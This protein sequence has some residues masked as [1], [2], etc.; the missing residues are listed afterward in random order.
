G[1]P[2]AL[3]A[4]LNC[5]P[6]NSR[7]TRIPWT[8]LWG[9]RLL[10]NLLYWGN[11]FRHWSPTQRREFF[12]WKW[13]L[14]KKKLG[15]LGGA[16]HRDLSRLDAGDLVDLSAY[17]E[18]QRKVWAAHV[19]S[20]L[21]YHP[22][23]FPGR[24]H[25]FRSPGHPL[26]CSF[27]PDYGWGDLAKG[28]VEIIIVPGAHEKI[29]EE[30]C[31]QVLARHLDQALCDH[32]KAQAPT[33]TSREP[34]ESEPEL[35]PTE[36]QLLAQWNQTRADFPVNATYAQPFEAQVERSPTAIAVRYDG[37]EL[38][39]AELNGHANQLARRLQGHGVKPGVLVGVCLPR[40]LDLMVAL[41]AVLK[42]GGAYLPL[43]RSYPKE[44]LAY[45]LADSQARLLLTQRALV[46]ELPKGVPI[47]LC[48]DAP[49]EQAQINRCSA[50]NLVSEATPDSLAYVIYTSGSTGMP[51]GVPITHRSLLNHNFAI[52]EAFGL[53]AS[54][55][56]LQFSPLSFDI[57]VEEIFPSWLCGSTVV[58][59]TGQAIA[60]PARF[61]EFL[62]AERISVLNLPT[63]YWHELVNS[64]EAANLPSCVRLVVIG[65]EKASDEAYKRWKERVTTGVV[66]MNGYG[67]TETTVTTTLHRA[68]PHEDSL[69]IGR[70]IANNQVA[71]LDEQ[72]QPVPTGVAGELYIGGAGVA[73]GYLHRPELTAERF[74][75]N[76]FPQ[77]LNSQRLYKTGDLGRFRPDGTI[78]LLG[79]SDQQVKIRGYRIEPGEI[80]AVLLAHPDIKD[81]VVI[82]REDVPGEKR[83]VGYVVPKSLPGPGIGQLLALI[84]EKLPAFMVPAAIL[85][86]PAMPLSPAGKV[87]RRALPA[88]GRTRP[89]L[90]H[91]PVEPRTPV[92]VALV[93]IWSEVLGISPIGVHDNFFDLGGHSLLA[94]Q[95]VSRIREML[96]V[97]LPLEQ[98]FVLPTVAAL[99]EHLGEASGQAQAVVPLSL[100]ASEGKPLPLS[101]RQQRIWFLDQFEPQQSPYNVVVG[102]RLTGLLSIPALERSLRELA[103]R[104]PALRTIFP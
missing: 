74:I 43:D 49:Q 88:P 41:L 30:P 64:L 14:L 76:P 8:P 12:R 59:R 65:G 101:V 36:R 75:L 10:R 7:Y 100:V 102:L 80:E 70:P 97:E 94:T 17:T 24:V 9:W 67:T 42:A 26:W 69:P 38:T 46:S 51:K 60:S 96:Q 23:P 53:Q 83:L 95:V 72:L 32:Q 44:R 71:I 13:S 22:E 27:D 68:R 33:V 19:H 21:D 91:P 73:P 58:L 45:M 25:L 84:K 16:A 89:E 1:Q 62:S 18:E 57:S 34:E 55:R 104:Q 35:K 5:A 4:L 87:D 54:D 78:E 61:W 47:V 29:L 86:V 52:L 103:W 3:L 2:V 79:R 20:L 77:E 40:S 93:E 56:V 81:A 85:K 37:K 6:P 98:F 15:S 39:Y 31:V 90:A 92:E 66:L 82:A 28:S 63:A 50:A 11:Y 99:A 48:V